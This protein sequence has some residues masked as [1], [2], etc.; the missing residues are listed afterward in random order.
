M[1]Y[2]TDY[3]MYKFIYFVILF[4]VLKTKI[5]PCELLF[6]ME[7][8]NTGHLRYYSEKIN[9]KVLIILNQSEPKG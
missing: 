5:R 6:E 1:S 4:Y 9:S 3:Y 8:K 7:V 2:I